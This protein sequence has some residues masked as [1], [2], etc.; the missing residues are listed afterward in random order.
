MNMNFTREKGNLLFQ[1]IAIFLTI[2]STFFPVCNVGGESIYISNII[3]I[4]IVML[5]IVLPIL[6]NKKERKK[7]LYYI[8]IVCQ[9]VLYCLCWA[10][11]IQKMEINNYLDNFA[12]Y[13]AGLF[14]QGIGLILTMVMVP[15]LLN[16]FSSEHKS[17]AQKKKN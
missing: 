9:I 11:V 14:I 10:S 17:A 1:Y 16:T 5:S 7:I 6:I 3:S 15:R 4:I 12:Q 8:S 13:E 2:I